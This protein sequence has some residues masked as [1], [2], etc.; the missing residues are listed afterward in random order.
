[1]KTLGFGPVLPHARFETLP[2]STAGFAPV[3]PFHVA[4]DFLDQFAALHSVVPMS[5]RSDSYTDRNTGV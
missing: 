2:P 3:E 4:R 5:F 1:R